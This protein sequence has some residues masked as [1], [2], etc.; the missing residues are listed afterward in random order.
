ME[1]AECCDDEGGGR[2]ESV[3]LDE[4]EESSDRLIRGGGLR[5]RKS[6]W[7]ERVEEDEGKGSRHTK[8]NRREGIWGRTLDGLLML[9][10][11]V[12][13]I[14]LTQARL[15]YRFSPNNGP[16]N[17]KKILVMA[18]ALLVVRRVENK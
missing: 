11:P 17:S 7:E 16:K 13:A 14:P 10:F 5:E 2:E 6:D 12:C 15:F 4:K 3:K 18:P 9:T 1:V 8:G